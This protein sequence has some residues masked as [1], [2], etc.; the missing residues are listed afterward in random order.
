VKQGLI[1]LGLNLMSKPEIELVK[2]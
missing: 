2:G 1:R